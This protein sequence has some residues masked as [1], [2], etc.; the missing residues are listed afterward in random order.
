MK[1]ISLFL[2]GESGTLDGRSFVV[3]AQSSEERASGGSTRVR[4]GN[5]E[6]EVFMWDSK[7]PCAEGVALPTKEYRTTQGIL[8]WNEC[9]S[10]I[11]AVDDPVPPEGDGWRMAGSSI[12]ELRLSKQV[13]LWFWERDPVSFDKNHVRPR[14]RVIDP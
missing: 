5:G 8:Q 6:Q 13:I 10:V 9:A 14:P 12:G 7:N 3:T 4:F 1:R 11:Q 2:K